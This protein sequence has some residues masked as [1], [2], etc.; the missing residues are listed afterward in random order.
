MEEVRADKPLSYNHQLNKP[1]VTNPIYANTTIYPESIVLHKA[2]TKTTTTTDQCETQPDMQENSANH[3][4]ETR[5]H[6]NSKETK[7]KD[8]Q[9]NNRNDTSPIGLDRFSNTAPDKGKISDTHKDYINN[10]FGAAVRIEGLHED[11]KAPDTE[12]VFHTGNESPI[13]DI[14]KL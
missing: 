11:H 13:T 14:T 3:A 6:N 12:S 5:E 10:G 2:Y 9:S 7:A 4:S 8:E 1:T